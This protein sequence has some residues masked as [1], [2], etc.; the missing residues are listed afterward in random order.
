[1]SCREFLRYASHSVFTCVI[2]P[3]L[4]CGRNFLNQAHRHASG[5]LELLL[6]VNVCMHVFVCVYVCVCMCVCVFVR[7][8]A[9]ACVCV[10][11]CV[12][13]CVPAPMA[14]NN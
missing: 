9:H 14:I 10:C 3:I 8:F 1:M 4:V 6:S 7:V 2:L 5:F 13:V 11:A 12:R